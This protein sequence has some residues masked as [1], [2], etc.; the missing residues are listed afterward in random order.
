MNQTKPTV[1]MKN[2]IA[3]IFPDGFSEP[4]ISL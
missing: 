4:D 3:A 1:I 2:G